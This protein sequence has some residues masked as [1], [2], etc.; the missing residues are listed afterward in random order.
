MTTFLLPLSSDSTGTASHPA[1]DQTLTGAYQADPILQSTCAAIEQYL[2]GLPSPQDHSLTDAQRSRATA[3]AIARLV[4]ALNGKKAAVT[5]VVRNVT[6]AGGNKNTIATESDSIWRTV[7]PANGRRGAGAAGPTINAQ[8]SEKQAA[9]IHKGDELFVGGTCTIT[10]DAR[11]LPGRPDLRLVFSLPGGLSLVL[12]DYKC[13]I[14]KLTI[15]GP[16]S[17]GGGISASTGNIPAND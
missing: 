7:T 12:S 11:K 14:G 13:R 1:T 2:Q 8:L 4:K 3:D 10:A 16:K 9:A 15:S 5:A 6:T 17:G